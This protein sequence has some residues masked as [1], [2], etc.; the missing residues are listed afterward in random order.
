MCCRHCCRHMNTAR[1]S[2]ERSWHTKLMFQGEVEGGLMIN[3][4]VNSRWSCDMCLEEKFSRIRVTR[5]KSYFREWARQLP[6]ETWIKGGKNQADVQ[7]YQGRGKSKEKG[8][9]V[10]ACSKS[11][12]ITLLSHVCSPKSYHWEHNCSSVCC[13]LPAVVNTYES[14]RLPRWH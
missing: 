5:E 8:S 4:W 13:Q 3:K 14:E 2:V 10:E 6:A 9:K 1:N 12:M 7:R 11:P